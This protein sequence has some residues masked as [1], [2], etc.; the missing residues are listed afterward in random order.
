MKDHIRA[1]RSLM[2][3][4]DNSTRPVTATSLWT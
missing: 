3:S 1:D 2:S 4:L